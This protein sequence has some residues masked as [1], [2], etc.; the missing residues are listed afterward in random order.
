MKSVIYRIFQKIQFKSLF[1]TL[2]TDLLAMAYGYK[3]FKYIKLH[4]NSISQINIGLKELSFHSHQ[5]FFVQSRYILLKK[6][7]LTKERRIYDRGVQ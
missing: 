5:E 3:K 1:R 4:I 6:K 2:S 7:P